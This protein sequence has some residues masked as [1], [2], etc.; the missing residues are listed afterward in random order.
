MNQVRVWEEK[1]V[2]P[3]Y[4]VGAPDK[5]PMFLEKRVYQGSSG[6]VYPYPTTETISREKIDKTYTAVYLEN[7]Y[8][9]IMILPELGGRIQ[10]AY[11]KT[12]DYDF[13]YYN[14]VIKPAL[15]GLL[16]PW[17]SGGIEFNWPQHHRPTTFMP[18][19]YVTQENEDG[20]KTVFVHDVDQ[21][22][23]TKGIAGFT[24]YPD[25]AFIEIRGQLYN[26]TAMPQTFLWWANP[27]VPA[28]D[29]TQSIFPPDV[30]STY[31]HG[32]RDVTSFPI[33]TGTYYKYD[34]SEGVDISRYKNVP[35]PSSFMAENSEYNF[36]GG[37][38]YQKEA[39]IL[40]V[41]DHHVSPGKKQ[42]VWGS[43]DFGK[44]WD[45]ILTDQD[46]PY[47]E[48]MTGV[49]TD[50]QPDF[51][52]LKP[53]E[54]KTFKQYFMPYKAVG[55]V[56]NASIHAM[57]NLEKREDEIYIC[58][59]ATGLY[60]D[61]EVV[62]YHNGEEVYRETTKI[63]PNHIYTK[64][65]PAKGFKETD[66]KVEVY[67]G[68]KLLIEYQAQDQGI[69]EL[70]EP[71]KAVKNPE[72]IMTTEELF[73]AGQHI[74]QYRHAT[75][76]PDPYYLEGL[77][78]DEGNIRI[79][80]AYGLLLMRRGELDK[81][82][83]HFRKALKRL[84]HLNPNPYDSEPYYNLGL[85]LFLQGEYED[86]FDAFYKATWTN[87]QQEMSFYYMAAI[88]TRSGDYEEALE[89]ID[90][91]LVKNSH[92]VKGRGLKA[93]I[94]R[95][96]GRKE[97]TLNMI[98]S[99]LKLDHFDFLS[100]FEKGFVTG[101]QEDYAIMRN[102][103]ENHLMIAR[104]YAESGSYQEAIQVLNACT[105]EKP[106]LHYYKGYYYK[107]MGDL[108]NCKKEYQKANAC[109]PTYCFPN[110]VEDMI[111]L[112]DAVNEYPD[113][114]KA[115]YYLGNLL[116][117]K[118]RFKEA[119]AM[120]EESEKLDDSYPTVLRNL[121]IGYY[122]KLNKPELAKEKL[123][124]AFD[125]DRQ[126]ARVFFELDQLHKKMGVPFEERLANYEENAGIVLK[127]DDVYIEFVTLLNQLGSHK[128]AYDKIM[129]YEFRPWE[130]AEGKVTTQYKTA[131]LEMAKDEI[132]AT[133]YESA[134][135][136]IQKALVYP[137][138]LGEGRLA[139]TKDNHLYY[140]LGLVQEA[141]GNPEEAHKCF[142]LATLGAVEPAGMMY[143][144][145][146]PADMI[147]YQGLAKIKL[148]ENKEAC[149]RFYK[150]LDY[151]E[152]HLRDDVKIDYFAVSLP[153]LLLF[154]E[155]LNLRNQAHCYYLMG[156]GK[157]GLGEKS[158]AKTYFDKVL[159]LDGNHQN[160][161]IYRKMAEVK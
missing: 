70:A 8:L 77:K 133:H 27:A 136:L 69:P 117:D 81:A 24:L 15:V 138:N 60:E 7:Q 31:D 126:D 62:V 109:D 160:A 131:L 98:E 83:E 89:F 101:E 157:L 65:I 148:G 57:V 20:S 125:L 53:Y 140:H 143:Y 123:E 87:E 99:N 45:R 22:Y 59:Y 71:A 90:K 30:H 3:T 113:G 49:Y 151:G 47:V 96:L 55:P 139:G 36:V 137:E 159:K 158:E 68:G 114:A 54:E 108:E 147:L 33:A 130:G 17:I 146:Q 46:G 38:D 115:S 95:K 58:S 118:L 155:D 104:D 74:E 37:Y 161:G 91:S 142:G 135:E 10:R 102:F 25:K 94:L 29:Y 2:I 1:V 50:N 127:R 73:L 41:A 64:T 141:L 72:E 144:Y 124:R 92:N 14:H 88:R 40:H 150:L 19:D 129:A 76:L 128:E 149:A 107:Q 152:R 156:L 28:N 44:A 6:K 97:E 18:V 48:L 85:V 122:N 67:G 35:V 42:W 80:N 121:S 103:H 116:Y 145:D 5:N 61:A 63:S 134:K 119:I 9:K 43:G 52:W 110:K 112:G 153:D 16:G 84:T 93:L 12:N 32:K 78:R 132:A 79:N 39:G 111:V 100:L 66:V 4:E 106:L 13:V 26:R 105:A 23:G 75:Y 86:A 21:M 11:D 154:D 82:E 120:W 34:Y 56:K 51:T